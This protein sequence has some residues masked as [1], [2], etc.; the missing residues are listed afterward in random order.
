[1][2]RLLLI[3]RYYVTGIQFHSLLSKPINTLLKA[4]NRSTKRSVL[5]T[6]QFELQH[7]TYE[8]NTTSKYVSNITGIADDFARNRPLNLST[9][10]ISGPGAQVVAY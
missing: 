5:N 6:K 2:C 9:G 4:H 10:G 1:M 7:C 8:N 3:R